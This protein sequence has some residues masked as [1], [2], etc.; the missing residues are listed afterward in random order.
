[1]QRKRDVV[2][3]VC[4][5]EVANV[6]WGEMSGASSLLG[7]TRRMRLIR[8]CQGTT[9]GCPASL[10]PVSGRALRQ[11]AAQVLVI[12]LH[13]LSSCNLLS[14]AH[15]RLFPKKHDTDVLAC[16]VCFKQLIAQS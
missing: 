13:C 4:R 6:S 3:K 5:D 7:P 14:V 9:A 16:Y 10:V 12:R 2:S 8:W 11:G 15:K 1:M